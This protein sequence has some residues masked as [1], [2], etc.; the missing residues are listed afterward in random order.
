VESVAWISERRDVLS[1]LLLMLS[2]LAWLTGI[3]AT[4]AARRRWLALSVAVY[5]LSLLAKP[6]G[7]TL[8]LVLVILDIYPLRRLTLGR[9]A[10]AAPGARAALR[11]KLPFAAVAVL[12]ALIALTFTH[13]VKGFA[14]YPL[15]VRPALLGYS[16][17]FSLGKTL[18]PLGL[19]PLYEIPAR[20]TPSDARLVIGGLAA[21]AI[22]A[23]VVVTRRRW[24]APAAAWAAYAIMLAP[25]SGLAIHGGPQIAA[26]R[27]SYLPALA[28]ALLVGGGVCVLARALRAGMLTPAS[29]RLA[30]GGVVVWLAGLGVLTWQQAGVWRDSVTLWNHAVTFAPDCA[31]CLHGL[32]VAWYRSGDAHGAV[33]PLERAV[34]LRPDL[35]F[36]ADLGL[37][38][39][40]TGRSR[41]AVPHLE[42]ALAQHPHNIQLE[43]RVGAVLIDAGR[44]EEARARFAALLAAR[45]DDVDALTGLGLALVALGRAAEAL[46]PLEKAATLSPRAPAPRVAL[47]RAYLGLGDRARADRQLAIVRALD[48]GLAERAVRR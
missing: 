25:V 28:L 40:T 10:W 11:E 14:D 2:V 17:A 18:L 47:A 34:A 44:P 43:R 27:Y 9:S 8:P 12:G 5:A 31:R 39:W 22:T 45:P 3:A 1:G 29:A 26:D 35:P 7:M 30:A 32:G 37:A 24:P 38:L 4:A 41:E 48:P 42:I 19:I 6:I 36:Q 13:E 21:A 15:W 33:A 23:A 20:W 16:L 46:A